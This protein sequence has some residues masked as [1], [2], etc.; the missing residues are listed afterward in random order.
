MLGLG[1]KQNSDML[2]LIT[3]VFLLQQEDYMGAGTQ[4]SALDFS[5]LIAS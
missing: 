5:W 4:T 2:R 3:K 1:E